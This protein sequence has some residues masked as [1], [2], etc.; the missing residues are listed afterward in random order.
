MKKTNSFERLKLNSQNFKFVATILSFA[1]F[2]FTSV[3]ANVE[4]KSKL[5]VDIN[6]LQ[7]T[8]T[9]TVKDASG[10]PLPGVTVIEKNTSNGAATDFDGQFTLDVSSSDAVLVF[11]SLGY[12][13]Q[14][15]AVGSSA[16]LAIQMVEDAAALDEVVVVGYGT[17]KKSLLTGA[18]SSVDTKAIKSASNQRVEQV[19]QGR[20]SGVTVSSSS[21]APGAG[22][23]IRIR[24]T[25][26][27]GNSE[28]LYIV[29]GMKTSS[30]VD[31]APGD[32]ANMEIL[33]DAASAAIYGTEGANGVVIITTKGGRSGGI[34]V[35]FNTQLGTQFLNT[36][37]E[38]MNGPQ[39]VQY[40]NEAGITSVVDNGVS[41]NWIDAFL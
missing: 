7:N 25:G 38:L 6:I 41:T 3:H 20:T 14:E 28:P 33:K 21:G 24:G 1:L 22:A 39:F 16:T 40:M 15:V 8:I 10:M 9:G 27:S 30:I 31:I 23:Q 19:L 37:F 2:S 5:D 32:I 12:K 13:T 29:D 34:K 36:D 18:I 4:S 35:G 26:S 11:S 17:K